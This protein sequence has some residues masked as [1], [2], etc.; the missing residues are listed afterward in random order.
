MCCFSSS[1]QFP[2]ATWFG[3]PRVAAQQ[4][5][6]E[7]YGF[8]CGFAGVPSYS[9]CHGAARPWHFCCGCPIHAQFE[10]IP[11]LGRSEIQDCDRS[12]LLDRTWPTSLLC[13][14]YFFYGRQPIVLGLPPPLT[15]FIDSVKKLVELYDSAERKGLQVSWVKTLAEHGKLDELDKMDVKYKSVMDREAGALL[16]SYSLLS[17]LV[18]DKAAFQAFETDSKAGLKDLTLAFVQVSKLAV[19]DVV[20]IPGLADAGTAI[21][22]LQQKL[23]KAIA[24]LKTQLQKLKDETGPIHE[25]LKGVT[26]AVSTWDQAWAGP[27]ATGPQIKQAKRNVQNRN[28][29]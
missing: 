17:D 4:A 7:R 2:V 22:E 1:I 10:H 15:N 28:H 21:S 18:Q 3:G 23:T 11:G 5:L 16:R 12:V 9:Q 19:D 13:L 24:Q 25:M 29:H 6:V 14:F 20:A 8:L 26:D 27:W